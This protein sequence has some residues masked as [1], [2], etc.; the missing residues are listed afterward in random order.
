MNASCLSD[1]SFDSSHSG[2]SVGRVS[3][4]SVTLIRVKQSGG[5]KTGKC[6]S[7]ARNGK[8]ESVGVESDLGCCR[9]EGGCGGVL[10]EVVGE[11][12]R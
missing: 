8:V 9:F 6:E 1:A 3:R 4:R 10:L 2:V 5:L 7:V 12:G 11:G